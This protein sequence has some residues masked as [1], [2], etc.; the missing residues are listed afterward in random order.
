[1]C[2]SSVTFGDTYTLAVP[3]I[4]CGI[5]LEYFDRGTKP[6][7]LLRPQDALHRLCPKGRLNGTSGTMFPTV[8][9]AKRADDIRPY[10][11]YGGFFEKQCRG[12]PLRSPGMKKNAQ[13][14]E[15]FPRKC[16]KTMF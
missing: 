14:K 11:G 6:C 5:R 8:D 13:K 10:G 7:S 9:F 4:F 1:G 12:D 15:H 16:S 2:P 3:K